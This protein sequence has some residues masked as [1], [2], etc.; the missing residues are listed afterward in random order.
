VK[1]LIIGCGYIG[2]PLGV[3]LARQGHE[4]WGLRRNPVPPGSSSGTI[5]LL[6]ADIADPASLARLPAENYEWVVN[7][8]AAG[9][10]GPDEYRRLY[11]EGTR[12]LLA[13]LTPLLPHRYL[14]TSSTSVYGQNDG[15]V[16]DETG[17]TEP[18]AETARVLIETEQLLLRA[19]RRED[20][21]ATLL[22]LAGI[23]GPGRGYWLRQFLANTAQI[24]GDGS[25]YLNMIHQADVVGAIIAALQRGR[26]GEI[27]NLVDNEPVTQKA[28]F[29]WLAHTLQRPLPPSVPENPELT[30][31][32]GVTNKRVS[33]LKLRQELACQLQFPTFRE[34][35]TAELRQLGLV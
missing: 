4:V 1:V 3:E 10:G 33:N 12:N 21:P 6:Q 31:R 13:W 26:S 18:G 14:Y 19:A 7:T 34:G 5:K 20:F 22:R 30:R 11:L 2:L 32:R 16:V 23:Y 29:E 25:R 27:Y 17:P 35:Y 15:A 24:E 8:A 9:G 28:C